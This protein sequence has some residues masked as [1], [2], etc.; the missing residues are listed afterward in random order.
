MSGV[1]IAYKYHKQP[2]CSSE[3]GSL[4]T[5]VKILYLPNQLADL[6]AW[7]QVCMVASQVA[8]SQI[9]CH[10]NNRFGL[11]SPSLAVYA[12]WQLFLHYFVGGW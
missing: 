3:L 11:N 8:P 12:D 10:V 9:G 4:I 1:G 2:C 7:L 5:M 6:Y